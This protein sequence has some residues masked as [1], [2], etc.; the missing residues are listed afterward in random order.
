MK[1]FI[2]FDEAAICFFSATG[3][4]LGLLIPEFFGLPTI[5]NIICCFAL[6]I[7]C[8]EI[9]EHVIFSKF[10]QTNQARRVL[11]WV[12][13]IAIFFVASAL[14]LRYLGESLK[15][16]LIEEF[17]W[18]IGI[19]LVSF[20]ISFVVF[21]IKKRI[22]LKRYGNGQFT[23]VFSRKAKKY[24]KGLN[25][26]NS[27]IKG[28]Y[29]KK[30]SVSTNTGTYVPNKNK[31]VLEFLGIPYAKPPT[32]DFRYKKTVPLEKGN[33]VFEAKY[34]GPS[35]PQADLEGNILKYHNQ[36]EDCLTLNI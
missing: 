5:V 16:D 35:A 14:S 2:T 4:G 21:F 12:V 34:F 24:M 9:A 17:E 33:K 10:I 15:D 28:D 25:G 22:I 32:G 3:Y 29:D 26:K 11:S 30:I 13:M 27:E 18:L 31:D 20:I 1:K 7:F 36:S 23:Y 8:E 6:G 19:P